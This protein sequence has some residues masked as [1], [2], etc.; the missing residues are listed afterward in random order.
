MAFLTLNGLQVD[1]WED[2]FERTYEDV[3][4]FDR[5]EGLSYEGALYRSVRQ[6]T[7]EIPWEPSEERSI[8]NRDWM[9]GRGH[10][11]SFDRVDGATVKFNRYPMDGGPGFDSNM[12]QSSTALFGS[13][14]GRVVSGG[15]SSV[16]VGFGTETRYS[17]S[18]WKQNT[19]TSWILHT[20]VSNGVASTYYA[21]STVTAACPW[22]SISAASGSMSIT[23]QGE[24]D[25]GSNA[26]THYDAIWV[27][28]YALTTPQIAA[29]AA[30]LAMEPPFPFVELNG[31]CI[32]DLNAIR[33]KTFIDTEPMQAVSSGGSMCFARVLK[34]KLVEQ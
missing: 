18:L 1:P 30:R 14:S 9:K 7:F 15:A 32:E 28:P 22:M 3:Q 4:N 17:I 8:A 10:S 6:W 2:S 31:D 19:A 27:V 25:G 21:T 12:V 16:T 5:S 20:H 11:W 13:W 33:V 29:R 24:N 23:L 26:T 34:V